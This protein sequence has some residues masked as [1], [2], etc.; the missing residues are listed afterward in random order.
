MLGVETP[1]DKSQFLIEASTE[2]RAF[3]VFDREGGEREDVETFGCLLGE[4]RRHV[5]GGR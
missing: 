2:T 5:Y 1:P 4:I 3:D